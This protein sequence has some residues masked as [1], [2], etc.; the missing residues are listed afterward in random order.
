MAVPE[1]GT[2]ILEAFMTKDLPKLTADPYTISAGD[3]ANTNHDK[4]LKPKT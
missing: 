2:Q 1:E 4:C 3:L